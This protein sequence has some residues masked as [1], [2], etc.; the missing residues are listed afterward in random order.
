MLPVNWSIYCMTILSDL[1]YRR[2][3]TFDSIT[4][5]YHDL[6]NLLAAIHINTAC[7]PN[8]MATITGGM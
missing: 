2:P 3:D 4:L 5:A 1:A 7:L 8:V 6:A